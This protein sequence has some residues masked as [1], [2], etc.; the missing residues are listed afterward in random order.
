M[1]SA[2]E[3]VSLSWRNVQ[4]EIAYEGVINAAEYEAGGEENGLYF[5]AKARRYR[6]RRL[7]QCRNEE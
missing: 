7:T 2:K 6:K 4:R 1:Q 3:L 5:V